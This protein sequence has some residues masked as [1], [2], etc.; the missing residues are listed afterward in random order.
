VIELMR[1][2]YL[3]CDHR[4]LPAARA[5]PSGPWTWVAYE[6]TGAEQALELAARGVGMVESMAPLRLAGE[7]AARETLR[8]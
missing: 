6:V 4:R 2:E 7:L 8:A 1:P 3:F 5:L